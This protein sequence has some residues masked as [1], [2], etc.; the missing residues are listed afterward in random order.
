[1]GFLSNWLGSK[2][3]MDMIWTQALLAAVFVGLYKLCDGNLEK[4][5]AALDQFWPYL[6]AFG[7]VG[8]FKI[9][10]QSLADIGKGKTQGHAE[11]RQREAEVAAAQ[12]KVELA[13]A[14]AYN[15]E[16]TKD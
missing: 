5:K 1:M 11:M 10:G 15:A 7:G 2:K 16:Q 3:T 8:V 6:A 9:A 13:K 4:V 12:L 14:E